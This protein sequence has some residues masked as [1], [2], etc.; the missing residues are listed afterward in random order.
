MNTWGGNVS[1]ENPGLG[2]LSHVVRFVFLASTECHAS[3][4]T[5]TKG[6]RVVTLRPSAY[7]GGE[8]WVKVQGNKLCVLSIPFLSGIIFD[9]AS[10]AK[11]HISEKIRDM[12]SKVGNHR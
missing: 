10:A 8:G 6:F 5:K 7:V 12:R 9:F 3:V 1:R 2:I 4:I 11:R